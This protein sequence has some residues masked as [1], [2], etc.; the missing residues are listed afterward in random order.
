[1]SVHS[2]QLNLAIGAVDPSPVPRLLAESLIQ[3][4]VTH[5][6]NAPSTFQLEF[7]AERAEGASWEYPLIATDLLRPT[8]RVILTVT[9]DGS[10]HLL[11]DGIITNQSLAHNQEF[12]GS[13]FSVS[14]EDVSVMMDLYEYSMEYPSMS[15]AMIVGVILAKY[16]LVGIVPE[17]IP[18][19]TDLPPLPIERVPQQNATDRAYLQ[20]LATPHGYQFHVRPGPV[21]KMNTAYWGPQ[22]RTGSLQPALTV[23][24]SGATNVTSIHFDY[25]ALAPTLVHGMVQGDEEEEEADFPI[26]TLTSLL[27]PPFAQHPALS[28][29]LPFVRNQ[30]FTDPRLG[31]ANALIKA[32]TITDDSARNV[33]VG[34]GEIDT[35]RYGHVLDAPGLVGVRGVGLAYDGTYYVQQVTHVLQPGQ[36]KQQFT[37][38]REGTG[39]LSHSITP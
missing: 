39:S 22:Q 36:Y 20:Q 37:L 19:L 24:E 32:Q 34:Q 4:Q 28:A 16:T 11:M 10:D 7:H 15:N 25:N 30:Q 17:I 1:M 35:V 31:Y 5:N 9:I 14:G 26:A 29:N 18:P 2:I 3:A 21:A 27:E 33:V 8:N 12:G 6:D 23:G 13:T 38:T